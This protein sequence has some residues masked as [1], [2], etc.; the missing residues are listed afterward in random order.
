M[1][2]IARVIAVLGLILH[3]GVAARADVSWRFCY[4]LQDRS[5]LPLVTQLGLNT[6][7]LELSP[8]DALNVQPRRDLIRAAH[9][10][11]LQVIVALP[12]LLTPAFRVSPYDEAYRNAVRETI[13]S[14]VS[15]LQDEPGVSAWATGSALERRLDFNDGDFRAYLQQ[16]YPTVEA[17][18]AQWGSRYRLWSSVTMEEARKADERAAYKVGPASVDLANYKAEAYRQ[19]M[20]WWLQAI[21]EC[22]ETRPV[23]TGRVTLYRSL[24]SIPEGYDTVCVSMPPD[25]LEPDLQAH[26]PQALD[27]A[28]RGGQ[29]RVLPVF[30]VPS[31]ASPVYASGGLREWAQQAALHGARGYGIE[32]WN[33]LSYMVAIEERKSARSQFLLNALRDAA[34]VDFSLTPEPTA[35]IIHSPYASGFE[36]TK[37]PVYGYLPDYLP[38]EPSGLVHALRLGT[39]YGLVDYLSVGDLRHVDLQRYGCV[40]A[41]AC[42]DLPAP[43][44]GQLQEYVHGGGA[45]VADLGLGMYQMR[46]WTAL[47]EVL[48]E[49]FG[50]VAM[51]EL[52]ERLGSLTA[53][54]GL[55]VLAPWPRGLQATGVFSPRNTAT[56][57]ATERRSYP[58][59]GWA[60]EAQLLEGAGPIATMSVRFDPEKRP[61]FAGVVGA[62]YGAGVALYATHPLWQYWPLTDPLSQVLHAR[63][64]ARGAAYELT[65]SGLL[66]SELYFAAGKDEVG[67]YN[68]GK[69]AVVGQVWAHDAGSHAYLNAAAQFAAAPAQAGLKPGTAL[70][71]VGVPAGEGMRL[72]RTGLVVQPHAGDA[73]ALVS[74]Y[75]PQRVVFQIAGAG[76]TARRV[77]DELR[78][79]GGQDVGVRVILQGGVYALAPQSRHRVVLQTR[80]AERE[81]TVT[82]GPA[83]ELDL[84]AVYRNSTVTVT[85]AAE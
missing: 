19:T 27:L 80:G 45:L 63:L 50:I 78:L 67:L 28:R 8:A 23:L 25:V 9:N 61:L 75:G 58:V 77:R 17:L 4:G 38:G 84:S 39:R 33:L 22:D 66:Q 24:L 6:L 72:R 64:M 74:E 10:S 14:L 73:T 11:G 55:R 59:S 37:Q 3:M 31:N 35:A 44:A 15:R 18:N 30:R 76:A 69:R 40:L 41:P 79:Q 12:T 7:Y 42:L 16:G 43:Q 82:A 71:Q 83:G 13:V 81:A 46:S 48:R 62:Q 47:P 29:F 20:V 53:A 32:D 51:G 2:R 56:A 5:D 21:R 54:E 68:R 65:Q 36:V 26:N 49:T 70:L 1:Y 34:Q 57:S 85:P 52:K 60:A